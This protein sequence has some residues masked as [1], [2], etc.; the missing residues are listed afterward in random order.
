MERPLSGKVAWVVGGSRGLGRA[1]AVR[2]AGEGAR[3]LV[4][5]RGARGLGEAVG[6]IAFQGGRAAH[7]VADARDADAMEAAA[8]HATATFGGLDLVVFAAAPRGPSSLVDGALA[9]LDAAVSTS[10][11]GALH[12]AR[13]SSKLSRGGRF[14][15]LAWRTDGAASSLV[16]A[17]LS[18]LTR[19]L[20]T[21]LAPRGVTANTL[22][23]GASADPDHVAQVLAFL[24]GPSGALVSGQTVDVA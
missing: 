11:L 14:L 3:V 24:A 16:V 15:A 18:G 13:A 19:T 5:G 6:E 7:L 10:W 8:R 1:A 22:T 4:T 20:A 21:E 23:A 17:G 12:A 9:E 2:L